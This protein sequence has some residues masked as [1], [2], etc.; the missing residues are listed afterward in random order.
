VTYC[1]ESLFL[2]WWFGIVDRC[3]G[4]DVP[5]HDWQ[6]LIGRTREIASA[7]GWTEQQT[8]EFLERLAGFMDS[9]ATATPIVRE[10]LRLESR[11]VNT[12]R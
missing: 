1:L 11:P 2:Q 4:E 5:A 8:D 12:A 6:V 3:A 9:R 7:N 10:L